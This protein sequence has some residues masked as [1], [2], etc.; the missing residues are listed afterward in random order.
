MKVIYIFLCY[1]KSSW[2]NVTT[3]AHYGIKNCIVDQPLID[4][5]YKGLAGMNE[6]LLYCYCCCSLFSFCP[7]QPFSYNEH[8]YIHMKRILHPTII[9]HVC[10]DFHCWNL[11]VVSCY[12]I[13]FPSLFLSLPILLALLFN[14]RFSPQDS[15][16][17]S[18]FVLLIHSLSSSNRRLLFLLGDFQTVQWLMLL[19]FAQLYLW[20]HN[21][22]K[23]TC[24]STQIELLN[25]FTGL[26]PYMSWIFLP[27]C[28]K[29]ITPIL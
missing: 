23:T 12:Y 26:H 11:L 8:L 17:L 2:K 6:R 10:D 5:W 14:F 9:W 29:S 7:Q 13:V 3:T 20:C 16:H 27:F 21:S 4:S 15:F 1:C 24:V 19:I 28:R 25:V 22:A 18:Y